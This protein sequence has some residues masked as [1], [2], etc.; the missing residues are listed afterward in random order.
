MKGIEGATQLLPAEMRVLAAVVLAQLEQTKLEQ[1]V[2]PAVSA[3]SLQLLAHLYTELA[4]AAAAL[5]AGMVVELAL[6]AAMAAVGLDKELRLEMR[7]L[8]TQAA[9]VV[10]VGILDQPH[11][12]VGMADLVLFISRFHLLAPQH[13]PLE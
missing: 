3:Y 4:A 12:Q 6:L 1:M 5:K 13:S 7:E 8:Q 11:M 10:V 9:A 2:Q